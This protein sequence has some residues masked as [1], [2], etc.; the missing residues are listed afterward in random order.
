MRMNELTEYQASALAKISTE[1]LRAARITVSYSPE[2]QSLFD[3]AATDGWSTEMLTRALTESL[4]DYMLDQEGIPEVAHYLAQEFALRDKTQTMLVSAETGQVVG[5]VP[6]DS[7]YQPD[8]VEREFTNRLAVPLAR[9]KP[10][11]EAALIQA[12]VTKGQE[13]RVLQVLQGRARSTELQIQDGDPRLLV[14]TRNGRAK[15]TDRLR[16]E[17]PDL[18]LEGAGAIGEFTRHFDIRLPADIPEEAHQLRITAHA[19]VSLVDML[20]INLRHD[21]YTALRERIRAQWARNIARQVAILTWQMPEQ[22]LSLKDAPDQG[23]LIC[24]P[25]VAAALPGRV[26]LAVVG[27]SSVLLTSPG[28]YLGI[29]PD[30]YV[31]EAIERNSQWEIAAGFDLTLHV[32]LAT[33]RAIRFTDVPAS[34]VSVEVVS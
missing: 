14:A 10:E 28:L 30:G 2:I 11:V 22:E 20:T 23:L 18:L 15:L 25:D 31:C 5:Q 24:D 6:P 4:P 32:D 27:A 16:Q 8:P 12:H 3:Q 1:T 9:I 26:C 19:S 21:L 29:E 7:I 34:G 17:L 33:V 13:S